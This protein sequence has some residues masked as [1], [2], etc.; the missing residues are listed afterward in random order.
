MSVMISLLMLTGAFF[1]LVATIGI[2]RFPDIYTRLHAAS[3]ATSF[4]IGCILLAVAFYFGNST[5]AIK[6]ILAIFFIFL[7]MPVAA[8]AISRAAYFSGQ[9]LWQESKIDELAE[10][11]PAKKPEYH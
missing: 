6:S 4:G 10:D 9:P 5:V 8:Y 2:L 7:T 1:M 3:K 11:P